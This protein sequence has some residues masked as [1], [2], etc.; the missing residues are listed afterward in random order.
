VS[1]DDFF[2]VIQA[3]LRTLRPAS[4]AAV[5]TVNLVNGHDAGDSPHRGGRVCCE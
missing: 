1:A 4:C 5:R 2:F 3:A